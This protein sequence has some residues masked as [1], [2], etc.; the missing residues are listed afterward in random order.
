M[1]CVDV[2]SHCMATTSHTIFASLLFFLSPAF[3]LQYNPPNAIICRDNGIYRAATMHSSAIKNES[4]APQLAQCLFQPS[5]YSTCPSRFPV[6]TLSRTKRDNEVFRDTQP[7]PPRRLL[8][9]SC[10]MSSLA[11]LPC[12]VHLL[13]L[14]IVP[15]STTKACRHA[16]GHSM[17]TRVGIPTLHQS[18]LDRS[19]VW[20]FV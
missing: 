8:L 6:I 12:V 5:I 7:P 15:R 16:Q 2:G 19:S 14:T 9:S 13:H 1:A 10:L 18:I 17:P 3:V 11:D 20:P 4:L